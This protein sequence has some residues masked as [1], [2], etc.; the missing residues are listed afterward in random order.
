MRSRVDRRP[1]DHAPALAWLADWLETGPVPP[2]R[3]RRVLVVG[4][5][6][7]ADLLSARLPGAHIAAG[8]GEPVGDG[9]DL[10][11]VVAAGTAAELRAAAAAVRAG[12]VLLVLT[13]SAAQPLAGAV[14]AGWDPAGAGLRL[15]AF[16]DLT[17]GAGSTA[18]QPRRWL[19][20]TYRRVSR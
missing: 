20:A 3:L 14:P 15:V 18:G 16:D 7:G 11:A 1:P 4:E 17:D 5:S 10:V 9:F 12:G 19:R 2:D 13:P 6:A 8:L